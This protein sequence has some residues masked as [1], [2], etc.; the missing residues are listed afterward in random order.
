MGENEVPPCDRTEE[1]K[2][3]E[4]NRKLVGQT[5]QA[6]LAVDDGEIASRGVAHW[7]PR[8]AFTKAFWTPIRVGGCTAFWADPRLMILSQSE[9][10]YVA[11]LPKDSLF[12][13][14]ELV[15]HLPDFSSQSQCWQSPSERRVNRS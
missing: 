14:T 2:R 12:T 8:R 11:L 7:G 6:D 15:Q 9:A 4:G 5:P 3:E 13:A 1:P 10:S